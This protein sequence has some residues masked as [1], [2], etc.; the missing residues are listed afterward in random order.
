MTT[1]SS[2]CLYITRLYEDGGGLLCSIARVPIPITLLP[3]I[4]IVGL[5]LWVVWHFFVS[6][7]MVIRILCGCWAFRH[8]GRC[9]YCKEENIDSAIL[10]GFRAAASSSARSPR[11]VFRTIKLTKRIWSRKFPLSEPVSSYRA[12][13]AVQCHITRDRSIITP[14]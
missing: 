5:L 9:Q 1:P 3:Y 4:F 14:P 12:R 8:P 6:F 11:V 10:G 13:K 7:I 2:V